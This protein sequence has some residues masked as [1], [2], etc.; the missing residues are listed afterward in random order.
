[1]RGRRAVFL[2]RDGT[3]IVEKEYLADPAQVELI[4]DAAG[5]L[6][7]LADTGFTLVV[8][9]N[10]SGIARGMYDVAAYESVDAR[11]RALLAERGVHVAASYYCPH[12]PDFGPPCDCRKPGTGL[13]ERAAR[14]LGL[15]L[16]TSWLIGDRL[17]DLEPAARLGA[18]GAVLVR[19]GYGA[20]EEAIAPDR[21][22]VTD[23]L[24]A[25]AGHILSRD[26]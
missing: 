4:P 25:A 20:Q 26:S 16:G 12:H 19:T 15:D 14:E 23:D 22:T 21:I 13:F 8:V 2:D 3:I 24:S 1:M 11:M 10:Q 18:R 9:T 5:A 7:R 6:R 17:R